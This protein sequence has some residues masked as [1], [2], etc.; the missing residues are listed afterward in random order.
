MKKF[1]FTLQR[2]Q[3]VKEMEEEQKRAELSGL[4]K[5]MAG[6]LDH[7]GRL[8]EMF[9]AQTS[10]YNKECK[11]GIG[12]AD[13]K[14]YGDYFEYLNEEMAAQQTLIEECQERINICRQEL[15]KLINEQKVLERMKD[16]QLAEYNAELQKSFDKEIEDF[17][18]GRL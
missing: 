14:S 1:E 6:L 12:K 4:D 16:E 8:H 3:E 5:E 2:L 9:E 15:L 18:Q 7:Q 11:R 10:E 13:L 17:M